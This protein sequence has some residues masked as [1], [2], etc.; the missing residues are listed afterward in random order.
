MKWK[1]E[2][3]VWG[4]NSCKMI[5]IHDLSLFVHFHTFFQEPLIANKKDENINLNT[6]FF[7]DNLLEEYDRHIICIY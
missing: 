1:R 4:C 5:S 3:Y 2:N 6:N 7:K